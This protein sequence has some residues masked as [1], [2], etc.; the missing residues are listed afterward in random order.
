MKQILVY[1]LNVQQSKAPFSLQSLNTNVRLN[2]S[3]N[4]QVDGTEVGRPAHKVTKRVDP[5]LL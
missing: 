4:G 3:K 5:R 2:E 1:F